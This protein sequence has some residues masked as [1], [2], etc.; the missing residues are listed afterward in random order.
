MGFY[1]SKSKCASTTQAVGSLCPELAQLSS[2]SSLFSL[3]QRCEHEQA[4]ATQLI[5]GAVDRR[6]SADAVALILLILRAAGKIEDLVAR[7][8]MGASSV[9]VRIPARFPR[10]EH[11]VGRPRQR[12]APVRW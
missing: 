4:V 3:E 6:P 8:S 10:V 5:S 12:L 7:P 9:T 1:F 11:P 2:D